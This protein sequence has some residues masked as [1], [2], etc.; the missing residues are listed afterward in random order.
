[1]SLTINIEVQTVCTLV[2]QGQP[3][4]AAIYNL[5]ESPFSVGQLH[6]YSRHVSTKFALLAV[7]AA[8]TSSEMVDQMQLTVS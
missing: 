7:A 3:K 5:Q 1:M 8:S 6:P 4:I 2:H